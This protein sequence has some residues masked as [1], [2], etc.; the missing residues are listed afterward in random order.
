MTLII[1]R[2]L[3]T[4]MFVIGWL[5]QDAQEI[6][7][8][9]EV[10]D[11]MRYECSSSQANDLLRLVVDDVGDRHSRHDLEEIR[12]QTPEK[13]THTLS[14]DGLSCNV[15]NSGVCPWV[16]NCALTL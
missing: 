5:L 3:R 13:T 10:C 6:S 11:F 2:L 4:D 15:H 16:Q 8:V 14:F 7:L 9:L 1:S 12:C